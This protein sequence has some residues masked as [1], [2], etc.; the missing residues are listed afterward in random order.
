MGLFD[1]EIEVPGEVEEWVA[2]PSGVA[3]LSAA[4]EDLVALIVGEVVRREDGDD[5]VVEVRVGSDILLI[6]IPNRRSE[7]SV[8]EFIS[9]RVPELQ[10]Y[11]YDL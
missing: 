6:E 9:F 8:K 1:V 11:P 3:S 2:I 5:P 4:T 10:L 7:L